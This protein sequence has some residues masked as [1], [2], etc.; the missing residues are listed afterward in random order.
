MPRELTI[1]LPDSLADQAE[2][3]GLLTPEAI[4]GVLRAEVRRQAAAS[5]QDAMDRLDALDL[6]PMTMDEV[7]AEIDAARAERRLQRARGA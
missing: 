3:L 1:T 4:E 6:P 5:L 7:Q 2:R